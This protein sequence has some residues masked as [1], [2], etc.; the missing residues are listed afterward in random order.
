[1]GRVAAVRY[2]A[3]GML[4]LLGCF[5]LTAC[6]GGTSTQIT[7]NEIPAVVNLAPAPN[8]SL[9]VGQF[10]SFTAAAQNSAGNAV[11]ET[12]AFQSSASNIV[13]VSSG[14]VACAGT[15]DSLTAPS[16]CTPG[17]TGV[18]QITAVANGVPSAPV[19]VYVHQHVTSVV[20]SKDPNQP[21][22]LSSTCVSKRAPSGNPESWV[23]Q[24]FAFNGAT[25]ITSSVGPFVWQSA[26]VAGQASTS[27]S[28]TL[29]G[30]VVTAPLN[31]ETAQANN[32]GSTLIFAS[33]GSVNS[34]PVSFTT[35]PVQSIS[36]AVQNN[37]PT[38]ITAGSALTVD[39]TVIDSLGNPLTGVSLT[40][41][42]SNPTSVGVTGG[43]STSFGSIG[44]VT[45]PAAGTG[46]VTASCTPPACNGGIVPSMPIYPKTAISFTVQ[47]ASTTTPASTTVYVTSTGCATATSTCITQ[48]VPITR[49]SA[50]STFAAGTPVSLPFIPNSAMFDRTGSN[51]YFGVDSTAFGTKGAMLVAGG[52]SVSGLQNIAG[53]VLAISPDGSTVIFSDTADSPPTVFVCTNCAGSSRSTTPV[54]I[55]GATAAAFSP[56]S[57]KAYIVSGGPCPGTASAGC[58]VVFSK[59]DAVQNIPLTAAASDVAFIGDGILGYIAGGSPAGGAFL[60]TCGPNTAGALGNVSVSAQMLRP[61]PDGQSVLALSGSTLETVTADIT[62]AASIGA[63]GCP[64][65]KGFLNVANTVNSAGNLGTSSFTPSQFFLS[66]DG[67]NAYILGAP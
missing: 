58:L 38:T 25:D 37:S 42:T 40:W 8:V 64:A 39:A 63:S 35:C 34:Q 6:G 33:V 50:T 13:T 29:I 41:S 10:L 46:S 1:M 2:L 19:T 24:A 14:G 9:E 26:A 66:R 30:P 15:W 31:Q 47:P 16:V 20:I 27:S 7:T 23:Y 53:K 4:G 18:A 60:P 57:L 54:L 49:A 56:D 61:L 3:S 62:G 55:S 32:P 45:A 65:P 12:F 52:S 11:T 59:V 48:I 67:T 43:T 5:F 44:S 17:S 28:V 22:T 51:E 36:L 21:P